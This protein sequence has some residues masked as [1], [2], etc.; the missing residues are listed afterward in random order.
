M[1]NMR[2]C[3]YMSLPAIATLTLRRHTH[4]LTYTNTYMHYHSRPPFPLPPVRHLRSFT[5]FLHYIHLD[6]FSFTLHAA[7]DISLQQFCNV[8]NSVCD[9]KTKR[10]LTSTRHMNIIYTYM[11]C[12]LY[13]KCVCIIYI[14]YEK[15]CLCVTKN[16][17]K[18]PHSLVLFIY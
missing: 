17:P 3:L 13:H 4:T 10:L 1:N 15:Q 7:L 16:P 6:L 9:I 5:T 11:R 2:A 8:S 14:S 18:V 12:V